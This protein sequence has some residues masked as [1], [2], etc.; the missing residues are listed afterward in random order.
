MSAANLKDLDAAG[1][2]FIVGSWV[3]KAP[4]D[5][6]SHFR[7]HGEAFTD[8]QVIGTITPRV[9]TRAVQAV[10][11]ET[12]RAEPVWDPAAHPKSWRAVWAYSR[13]GRSGTARR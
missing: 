6:A 12:K 8:G 1:L 7:W 10:N 11:D 2:R 9:A 3:T 13:N 5:L 4:T